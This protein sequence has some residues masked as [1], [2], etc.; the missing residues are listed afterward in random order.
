MLARKGRVAMRIALLGFLISGTHLWSQ[1]TRTSP[2]TAR[3]AQA[4]PAALRFHLEPG[5]EDVILKVASAYEAASKRRVAP[6]QF[7]PLR[8]EP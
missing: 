1:D 5:K 4:A 6:P 3:S 7:G 8:G 2:G